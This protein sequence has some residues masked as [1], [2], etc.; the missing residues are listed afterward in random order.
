V[1]NRRSFLVT[2]VAGA[3]AP[4]MQASAKS[5]QV[6]KMDSS[7]STQPQ[8]TP[9]EYLMHATVRIECIDGQ[10]KQSVGTGFLFLLFLQGTSSV[11]VVIT[12]KHVIKSATTGK[13]VLT[14]AKPNGEP[15]FA[16]HY[17][18]EINDFAKHWIGHPDPT[19]DLAAFPCAG[20]FDRLEKQRRK[21]FWTGLDQ[22]LIPTPDQLKELT[23]V[24]ELLIV[25]YPVGIWD[26]TNNAPVF[27]RGITA[28]APY[29]DF[30]GKK[31]FL[32]DAAIFPDSSGSPVLLVNL[33]SWG[34]RGGGLNVG[35]RIQLLGI[36]YA[37]ATYNASGEIKIQEVP[38]EM[39]PVPVV[40]IP[41]NL[42]ICIKS[43]RILDFEPLFVKL[44]HKPPDGYNMRVP[45]L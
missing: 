31:E 24:E 39:R 37:V 6:A 45:K 23:P 17:P 7:Q 12:N 14:L 40:S 3:I 10:G 43:T 26:A 42:G 11:P 25:G 28:T 16:Q 13:F 38:T 44:G 32:I 9:T 19:V 34:G 29:L 8:L 22:S 2:A 33:G 21:A 35:S 30:L 1:I 15:D 41:S 18:I 36:N 5:F 27:R 4:T 20:I